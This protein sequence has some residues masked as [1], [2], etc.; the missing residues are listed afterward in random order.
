MVQDDGERRLLEEQTRRNLEGMELERQG[1]FD[2]A[3]PLYERNVAD[4]FEGD[5]PFGRLVAYYERIG[6]LDEAK[7]VL[8][9]GIDVMKASRRRT[10]EDRRAVLKAFR[11][12]LRLVV[13]AA[14]ARPSRTTVSD[15]KPQIDAD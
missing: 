7:R 10:T 3:M 5:W 8:E 15:T 4:G 12:R 9:R 13:K 6:R 1:R 14:R 2:E 11:G